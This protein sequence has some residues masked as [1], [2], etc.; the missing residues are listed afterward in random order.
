MALWY[1]WST[2]REALRYVP[3]AW[4]VFGLPFYLIY[5]PAM[6]LGA[7][8]GLIGLPQFVGLSVLPSAFS[9]HHYICLAFVAPNRPAILAAVG[10]PQAA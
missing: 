9:F 10:H 2:W 3:I 1:R 6:F 8:L 5:M 4:R 7:I